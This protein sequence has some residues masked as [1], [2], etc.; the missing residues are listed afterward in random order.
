M[1]HL[2]NLPQDKTQEI[3]A[4]V[5]RFIELWHTK[6]A[7]KFGEIFTEDA[8][9]TDIVNQI[10]RGRNEIIDQHRFPFATVNK[11][12][13]FTISKAYMRY[14]AEGLVLVTGDWALTKAQSPAGAPLPDRNGVLQIICKQEPSGAWKISLVHN[15]DLSKVYQKMVNTEMRFYDPA[16]KKGPPA[17]KPL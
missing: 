10:A 16:E 9:F 13:E 14:I 4:V 1:E 6:D 17:N 7:V 5:N 2:S 15:T 3:L 11:L 12:A 8:E